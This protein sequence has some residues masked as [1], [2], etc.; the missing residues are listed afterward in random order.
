MNRPITRT[1]DLCAAKAPGAGRRPPACPLPSM[2][3]ARLLESILGVFRVSAVRIRLTM[4]PGSPTLSRLPLLLFTLLLFVLSAPAQNAPHIG[5]VYPAGG[6]PTASFQ[7][8]VGGQ[9]LNGITNAFF[10]DTNIQ[11]TIIEYTRPLNGKEATELREKAKELQDKRAAANQKRPPSAAS[12]TNQPATNVVWTPQDQKLLAEIR[13]KLA[14]LAPNKQQNPAISETVVLQVSI[15]ANLPPGDQEL[16]LSTPTGLSNPL[17][18]RVGRTREFT[19]R[20]ASAWRLMEGA[21]FRPPRESGPAAPRDMNIT[22]PATL[23]GQILPGGVDRFHFSARAGRR[24]VIAAEARKLIPYLPDAVPGWFQAALTVRDAKGNEL[25]HADHFRFDPDPALEFQPPADGEYVLEIRDSIYRGREDFVYRLTVGET[26]YL[27]DIFPLGGPAGA[28]TPVSLEGWNLASTNLIID[29]RA[30]PPGV[31]PLSA[32]APAFAGAPAVF[33]VG[34][35]PE[36]M[37]REPNNDSESAQPV[38]LPIIIN[39]RIDPPGDADVFRFE[40]HRGDCVVA[41]VWA[42]RLNSPLDSAIQLLDDSGRQ[43]AFNDDYEDK[44]SGLNTHHADSYL[45]AT[46]PADGA[47][48]LRLVDTQHQGGPEFAYRLRL[49]ALRP[50]FDLRLVPSSLTVR[51]GATAPLTVYALRRDGCSNEIALFLKDAP[52]GFVL[53]GATIPAGQDRA[54]ITLTAPPAPVDRPVQLQMEGMALI[55]DEKVTRPVIPAEDM[56]Q[57]FAYR[58]LVP[59]KAFEVEVNGRWLPRAAVR[60]LSPLPLR[61]PPGG[62]ATVKVALPRIGPLGGNVQFQLNDP[63]KGITLAR[64]SLSSEGA[65][66]LFRCDAS[67]TNAGVEGNL[68]VDLFPE[69]KPAAGQTNAAPSRPRTAPSVL[70]AIPFKITVLEQQRQPRLEE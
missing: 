40:G 55:D 8:V 33:E 45:R 30:R 15:P 9:F 26:P 44:G 31:Y 23:N 34:S 49:S 11:A 53:G 38:S 48:R 24:L 20:A 36:I 32:F 3:G 7:V 39:G 27:T 17:L 57:A 47:Y 16:R 58:H 68:I 2:F 69:R 12:A 51:A 22:L 61:I 60:L 19:Q 1:S 18:F 35:L 52:D 59:S 50:D 14:V 10:S 5:Y 41:E 29:A 21:E 42:R 56:M 54:R 25:A 66:L 67:Q 13:G 62:T 6:L 46:L 43:L 70:P 64:T 28:E 37:E 65:D 4:S 63:P